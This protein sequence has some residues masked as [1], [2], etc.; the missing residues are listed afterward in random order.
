[1]FD[2]MSCSKHDNIQKEI[3]GACKELGINARQEYRGKGWRAD[4][5]ASTDTQS[6]AFEIQLSPQT[7]RKTLERQQKYYQDGIIGCWFF[8]NPVSKFTKER[9]DLPL[10]YV[11][12]NYD[13]KMMVNLGNRRKVELKLFLEQFMAG[14]I[15]FQSVAQTKISQAINVVFYEM[16][17]WKCKELNHLFY[18]ASPF[19]SACNAKIEYQ[20]MLWESDS[21]EYRPEI[22]EFAQNFAEERPDLNL[23]LATIKER[24]S[25]TVQKAYMSFGCCKCDSIF[26]DFYVMDAK[27][28]VMNNLPEI[29]HEGEIMLKDR[30]EVDIPHW[31]F[32]DSNQ[33]C[34]TQSL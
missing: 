19:Y 3:V 9:P 17:C 18:V 1:M 11:E 15:K 32:P 6:F 27:L 10:F 30:I 34:G 28:D 23:K 4:V 21:I 29:W 8:E 16:T 26:G 12:Q 24:F 14:H 2:Q 33:F 13:L 20:E 22:I 31:C 5:F 7:L 25:N